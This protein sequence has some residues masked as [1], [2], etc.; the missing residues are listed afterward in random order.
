[1]AMPVVTGRK[2]DSERFAGALRTYS[3]EAMMQDN[4]ALQ[5][6]TSHNLGQNFSKVFDLKYQTESGGTE[7]AWNTSWGVSTRMIGGLVM[8]HGD[9][10]GLRVPPL[11]A[12]TEVVIVPIWR[13]DEER[14]RVFEA[15][16]RI[17]QGLGDWERREPG[18]L[19][20]H[21]DD[22][23]GIKPGA[24]Y[25][26]WELR[27]VPVRLELGPRDLD[28]AQAVAVRRDTREK[29]AVSLD[30]LGE[31]ISELLEQI[32]GDMLATARERREANS[33]RGHIGYDRFREVM[34]GDGAFVYAGWCGDASC[35]ATIKEETKATI[36]VLPDEEFRSAEAPTKCMHCGRAAT[37]EA[38]WAK[39][40]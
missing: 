7:Y 13:S 30:T 5:A 10:T 25:F 28:K 9:D 35:E 22:R 34:N 32:Q 29:R 3:C 31:D 23:E 2:T 15:A 27:G 4:K 1:M 39:A 20:V 40:Y 24:K 26:E 8:T 11:L 33:I 21:V 18:R 37:S 16:H 19:R 14:G 12:P 6:G 38:L 36:R 17:K